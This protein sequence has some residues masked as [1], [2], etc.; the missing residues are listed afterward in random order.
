MLAHLVSW[1]GSGSPA[2]TVIRGESG[3][4]KTHLLDALTKRAG[5]D[6][7][8]CLHLRGVESE[9][10]L[11]GAGLL[12]VLSP[13]R[14]SLG[15]V[16]SR[17]ADALS[18]LLGWGSAVEPGDRF[19]IGAA[20]LSLLAHASSTNP[21]LIAIDDVQWIDAE[22][23]D[24]FIFAARRLGHDRVVVVLT[25]RSR[26][27]L[28][29]SLEAFQVITLDGLNPADARSLLGP[30][31]SPDVVDAL[32]T[33]TGGNPLALLECQRALTAP[34]R[35]G[36]AP[37]PSALP[38]PERLRDLYGGVL[39]DLSPGAWRA[40]VLSAASGDQQAAPV[41]AALTSEGWD[42][43]TC[44][45]ECSDVVVA[46]G[47]WLTF[48]HPLVR[49]ATWE[50]A[51]AS[52]RRSAHASLAAVVSGRAARAWHGAEATPGQDAGLANELA[53]VAESD[54]SRCGFAAASRAAERAARLTPDLSRRGSWLVWATEDAY[55]AGDIDRARRLADEVLGSEADCESRARVL[56]VLGSL[57]WLHGTFARARER[58]SQ[59]TDLA[60]G[61]PLVRTLSEL[62]H[63]CHVLDD[64]QGMTA[65]ADRAAAVAD[66]ADPEQAMVA[67][68]LDGAA[69][70]VEGRP[71][72]GSPRILEAVALLE[73]DPVLRDDPRHLVVSLLCARW[74]MDPSV[75]V[76][77]AERR[78]DRARELGALGVLA[79][80]LPLFSAGLA[81]WGDHVRAYAFAGEA[82]ELMEALRITADPGAAYEAYASECAGRGLHQE[83]RRLLDQ[84]RLNVARNGF[85]PMPPHLARAVALCALCRG[86]LTEVV[87][88]LEDQVVRFNGVGSYLEPLGVAPVLVE[89]YLGL[90]RDGA[91]RDLTARFAASQPGRP[92]PQVAA[93]V[94]RCEG[95]VAG[96][97]DDA[98]AAFE[99][100]LALHGEAPDRPEMARTQLLYGMR[101][102][103]GGRRI[104]AREQL[105]LARRE[106]VAM[107][108]TLWAERATHELAG[109]GERVQHRGAS[110]EPLTSQETRVAL[111][112]ASG[113]KNR[114]VAA[115]L[116]LSAKTVEH[117]VG[118]V[119]RK[120]GLRSRTELARVLAAETHGGEATVPG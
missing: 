66:L 54:R 11:S 85:D 36:A 100:S 80:G 58:F 59:A 38:V 113:L 114:E 10:A 96:S 86:D 81:W 115:A 34:Q 99:R 31:F 16:P 89:A 17:Q 109:T 88:V 30:G 103:R 39:R 52:E 63:T 18:S 37:L 25:H 68:Y 35:I 42:A 76:G 24:A 44:L 57:E 41:L 28:A 48:R 33:A 73:S 6:G 5:A 77:Y 111:L 118:N 62:F 9:A 23:A 64:T 20:T 60:T 75:A 7:W 21:L 51:T 40:A 108:L 43:E 90:G 27:P 91:A 94:A 47:G 65:A 102:R 14:E 49:S 78:V 87:E 117:H 1:A 67:A 3:S 82:V 93:M 92:Y 71:E 105:S 56:F 107:E 98:A 106:F 84:A 70:I 95:L 104:A 2:V 13:L 29:V 46:Q 4:G 55:V 116:F 50:R 53:A 101:L 19:L 26:T 112:V 45:M 22:S 97:L 74:L 61:R 119:L 15:S 32:V 79:T 83:A 72:I 8:R 120:R 69:R 12:S 110:Q